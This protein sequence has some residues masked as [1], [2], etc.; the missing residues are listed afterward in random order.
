MSSAQAQAANAAATDA[1][2][3]DEDRFKEEYLSPIIRNGRLTTLIA[4]LLTCLPMLY[5]WL[6]LG[7]RPTW[8]QIMQGWLNILAIYFIIYIV[9][10]ISYYPVMG[11]SGIYIGYLAGNI[12]SVRLPA[13]LAAQ[14]A[15]NSAAGSKRGDIV[16]TIAMGSSVFVNI[17]FVT[18]AAI[19]GGFI[20]SILPQ[21][22]ISSF[23]YTLPAILGAVM[24]QFFMKNASFV[25]IILA[26]C[27][28]IAVMAMPSLYKFPL[29]I[30]ASG[31]L[32][33]AQYAY[34]KKQAA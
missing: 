19:A 31:V 33:Y 15:T 12:P 4:A 11:I 18:L 30:L 27:F 16:G 26:V 5:L 24:A 22:F 20:L 17:F 32:G 8:D 14:A 9:E 13:L 1:F 28:G 21:F 10:P 6:G 3:V 25:V 2:V 34:R 23:S 7:L 29:A